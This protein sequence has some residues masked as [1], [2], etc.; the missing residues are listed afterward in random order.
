MNKKFKSSIP[1]ILLMYFFTIVQVFAQTAKPLPVDKY[2]SREKHLKNIR[3]LTFTGENAEAYLSFDDKML[4]FQ[5]REQGANCDQIY[6]M[7]IDGEHKKLISSGKGRTTCS[8]YL[9]NGNI[10]YA[11]TALNDEICPTPPDPSKGY[12]WPLYPTYDIVI[13]DSSNGKILKKLT[14]E[15]NYDA[16]ATISPKGDRIVFTS[17]RSGDIEL[18]SCDLEGNDII[19]LTD[20]PGYDGG[21]FYSLDGTK[22]VYRA[23][24]PKGV[25]LDSYTKLLKENLIRPKQLEIYVMDADGSNKHQITHNGKANFAPFFHP[26]GKRVIFASNMDDP[27]GRNFDIFMVNIDGTSLERIT[28]FEEFDGFPMF[29]RDGKKLIF[30]SNRNNSHPGDTNVFVAD[31]ED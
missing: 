5:S 16:E 8:Y 17:L 27:K 30:C 22:I 28:Y 21:A 1:F 18:Y 31:W 3:Q 29:T 10:L 14:T 6:T 19:Q 7:T 9:P 23:S 2:D 25:D 20:E 15:P 11:T 13:A 12:V 26:D 4:S 24:R